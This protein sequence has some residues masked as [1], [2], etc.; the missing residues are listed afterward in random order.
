M[1]DERHLG[2]TGLKMNLHLKLSSNPTE[3]QPLTQFVASEAEL[4]QMN[5]KAFCLF[6]SYNPF[7][8]CQTRLN[9]IKQNRLDPIAF[10]GLISALSRLF[11]LIA[12]KYKAVSTLAEPPSA[13]RRGHP[14]PQA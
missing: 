7:D 9:E 10:V 1:P 6:F 8:L 11:S 2:L 13:F 4:D 12:I 14:I 3:S 5:P